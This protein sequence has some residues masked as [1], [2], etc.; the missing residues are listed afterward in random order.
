MPNR[1]LPLT[2]Q[3]LK[4]VFNYLDVSKLVAATFWCLFYLCS[5]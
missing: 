2:P 4:D 5:F 1:F 3:I